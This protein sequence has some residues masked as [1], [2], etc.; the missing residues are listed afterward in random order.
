MSIKSIQSSCKFS[1]ASYLPT[2]WSSTS[3]VPRATYIYSHE[4]TGKCGHFSLSF[5]LALT[6]SQI[7]LDVPYAPVFSP[8]SLPVSLSNLH[9]ERC[10]V[11]FNL[12]SLYSQLGLAEDRT[13]PDDVKRA[14]AFYQVGL[15]HAASYVSSDVNPA[16]YY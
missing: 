9:F 13:N 3:Q 15:H 2:P 11:L 1:V 7:T 16:L 5:Q 12:A 10:C 14:R 8:D 4:T 6:L